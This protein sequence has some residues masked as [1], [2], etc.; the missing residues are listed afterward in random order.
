MKRRREP[1]LSEEK[2]RALEEQILKL[3][4]AEKMR[5]LGYMAP[6]IQEGKGRRLNTYCQKT[7][8]VTGEVDQ[9]DLLLAFL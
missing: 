8:E 5:I 9:R 3:S 7:G 2:R 1:Q 6:R 4:V